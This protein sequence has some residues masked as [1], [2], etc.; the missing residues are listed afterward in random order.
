[1]KESQ[2]SQSQSRKFRTNYYPKVLLY[3]IKKNV[4]KKDM[5][6]AVICNGITR[7]QDYTA[8]PTQGLC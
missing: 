6:G 7:C 1:M 2:F 3:F 5:Q 8:P 4:N